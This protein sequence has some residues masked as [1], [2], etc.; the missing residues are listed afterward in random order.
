MEQTSCEISI[1][2][3]KKEESDRFYCPAIAQYAW[4]ANSHSQIQNQN[5]L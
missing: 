2:H 3:I 5:I 1:L 4:N